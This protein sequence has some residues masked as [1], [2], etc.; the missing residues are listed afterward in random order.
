MTM[1]SR[2]NPSVLNSSRRQ[3]LKY[4][5]GLVGLTIVTACAQAPAATPTTASSAPAAT[6][7]PAPTKAATSAETVPTAT[8]SSSAVPTATA[9]SAAAPTATTAPAQQAAPAGKVTGKLTTNDPYLGGKGFEKIAEE[10]RKVM[11]AAGLTGVTYEY[12]QSDTTTLET[13]MAAGDAPDLIYVYPELAQ[14]W[15]ARKQIISLQD[16]INGDNTWKANVGT[17]FKSMNDGYT[18]KG[19]LYALTTAAEAECTAYNPDQFKKLN[20]KTPTELGPDAW[21]IEKFTET[22]ALVSDKTGTP[23]MKGWFASPEFNQGIGDILSGLGGQWFSDDGSKALFNSKEFVATVDLMVKLVKDG[24]ALNGP[25]S[26][27]DGQWVAAALANQLC[28]MVIAGDWAWGWAHKTQLEKKVFQPEMFYI[29]AGPAG[30]KPIA[31]SAGVAIFA[32]TQQR[33]AALAFVNFGFTKEFQEVAAKLYEV[34]PQFP[35]RLDA[36]T[37]IFDRKLLP[38]FFPKLFDGSVPSPYTPMINP[39]AIYGV[40][41]DKMNEMFKGTETRPTQKVMDDLNAR[42]QR[43]IDAAAKALPKS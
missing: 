22:A 8:T 12:Q 4:G 38:D 40:L 34:S 3:F 26:T 24:N 7:V 31:H 25:Q 32:R 6:A 10:Y 28:A 23:A 17:F 29:P 39:Y 15:A 5:F 18:Y 37:P 27:K 14:P 13:R 9:A 41:G 36:A 2:S 1:Q 19:Q 21:T 16:Y 11:D 35:A 43:D 20:V 33:D 42:A 30:R